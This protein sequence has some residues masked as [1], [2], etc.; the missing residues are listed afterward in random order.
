MSREEPYRG[1]LVY[2]TLLNGGGLPITTPMI[3]RLSNPNGIHY[4]MHVAPG[5]A[6]DE[7]KGDTD[8]VSCG[9][10]ETG[11]ELGITLPRYALKIRGLVHF[12]NEGRTK[13]TPHL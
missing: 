3:H 5:G 12:Q 9:I 6:Y 11:E 7:K 4:G 2:L 10:R 1:T 8:M 13:P